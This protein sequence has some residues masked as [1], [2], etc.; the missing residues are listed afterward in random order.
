MT[1]ALEE[2]MEREGGVKKFCDQQGITTQTYYDWKKRHIPI[3]RAMELSKKYDV[4]IDRL[5]PIKF[6]N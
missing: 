1:E 5:F 6:F 2:C 4:E 3:F